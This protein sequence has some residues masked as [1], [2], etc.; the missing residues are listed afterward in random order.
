MS[1]R[2]IKIEQE[3]TQVT[4]RRCTQC[5]G[6]QMEFQLRED[7]ICQKC[8]ISNLEKE[9]AGLSNSVTELTNSKTELENKVTELKAQNE[10]MENCWNCKFFKEKK[11]QACID[12]KKNNTKCCAFYKWELAE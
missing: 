6:I 7:G 4:W 12:Y 8:Y 5:N 9:N 1:L 3:P 10:K 2:E 11:Y